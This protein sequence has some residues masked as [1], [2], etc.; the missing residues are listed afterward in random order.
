MRWMVAVTSGR[1]LRAAA[2]PH[3]LPKNWE[4]QQLP[5]YIGFPSASRQVEI[6]GDSQLIEWPH[7]FSESF[8]RELP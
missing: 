6:E 5:A 8:P 1:P 4:G 2:G 3:L 7:V